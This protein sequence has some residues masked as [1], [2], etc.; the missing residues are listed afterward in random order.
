MRICEGNNVTMATS[1]SILQLEPFIME[2][3]QKLNLGFRWKKYLTKF[4][5]FLVAM[6]ITE[7]KRKVAM[8][9]HFG[10]DY[11]RDFIDNAVPKVEGYD[12]TVECLNEHLN[13]KTNNTF[14]IY[15]FQK[16]I[17]DSDATDATLRMRTST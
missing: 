1:L 6:N 2:D 11:V 5:N 12:A 16:T 17:Q 13:P 10:G 4:E 9:L 15:R 8:L 7:D 3:G 14:E